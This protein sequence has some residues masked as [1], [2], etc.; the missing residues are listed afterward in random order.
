MTGR[1]LARLDRARARLDTPPAAPV[2]GQIGLA[3]PKTDDK[4]PRVCEYGNPRC[5]A[6]R[7]RFYPG[8]WFCDQHHAGRSTPHRPTPDKE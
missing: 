7:P 3:L 2:P 1:G 6:A 5:G 4:P 8:G